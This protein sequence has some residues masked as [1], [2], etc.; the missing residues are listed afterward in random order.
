MRCTCGTLDNIFKNFIWKNKPPKFR[1]EILESTHR[2]GGLKMTNLKTFDT[3][4]KVSWLKRLKNEEDG[5]EEFPRKLNIH[6]IILFGDRYHTQILKYTK[7]Y[8]SRDVINASKTL[9]EKLANIK[10]N[11]SNI[12]LWFNSGINIVYRKTWL[13]KGY[14][15]VSDIL[16]KNGDILLNDELLHRGLFL[17]FLDYERLKYDI[18]RLNI[19]N[20]GNVNYGPHIPYV[21]FKMGYQQKG[22]SYI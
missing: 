11:A 14:T 9:L 18:S 22:C 7:N 12:P 3:A 15:W 19:K 4:L 10:T 2:E 16:D 8:F 20:K 17:N 6:K 21:L 1:R 13:Q 5:W